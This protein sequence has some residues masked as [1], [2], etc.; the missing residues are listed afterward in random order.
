MQKRE[1]LI[2]SEHE[3]FIQV[4]SRLPIVVEKTLG[5]R[6]WDID[7]NSYLDFLGGIAVD[8]LGHSHPKVLDAIR[9]QSERYLHLSNYFYQ[10]AQINFV[11]KL[12]DISGYPRI[13]LSNSGAESIEG[14]IKLSRKWGSTKNKN[15]IISFNGAF[16][17]RTYGGLSLMNKPIYKDGMGPF[18]DNI[19]TIPYNSIEDLLANIDLGVCAVFLEFVQGEGG[20]SSVSPEF[21]K[22]LKELKEKNNF[23]IVADEIQAGMGRTGKF[24]SFDHFDITP[25]IV[26]LSKGL[27]GGLPLGAILI[28]EHLAEVFGK[29]Q[30]GTTFGGNALSCATG[31]VVLDELSNGLLEH[32]IEIGNYMKSQLENLKNEF[33]KHI[34]QVRGFGL[35]QGLVLSF[36]AKKLVD[37]MLSHKVIANATNMN[38]LRIVPPYVISKADVDEFCNAIALSLKQIEN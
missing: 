13:F 18:L 22:V 20:I 23:L 30:H 10:D 14:A 7:G 2:K 3:N 35:M 27:G 19:R 9:R 8:V 5:T 34:L 28:Q 38:V 15:T 4:Y 37:E 32:I 29:S 26:T 31:E 12:S 21:V 25:D 1:E 16:H 11:Q 17:G 24:F 6:I 36:E 33:P